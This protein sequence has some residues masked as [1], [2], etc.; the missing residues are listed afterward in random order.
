[1]TLVSSIE[2]LA[3]APGGHVF[4]RIKFVKA[5]LKGY[6]LIISTK[7]FS[8]LTTCFIGDDVYSLLHR[9]TRETGHDPPQPCLFDGSNL[10]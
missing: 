7:L 5:I 3:T 8:I 2:K 4:L 6:P 10:L 9:Y 1:M